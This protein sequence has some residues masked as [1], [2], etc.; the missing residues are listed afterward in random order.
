[1]KLYYWSKSRNTLHKLIQTNARKIVIKLILTYILPIF[2]FTL[3]VTEW[4]KTL[5]PNG[6]IGTFSKEKCCP[7]SWKYVQKIHWNI[8]LNQ[9]LMEFL[10]FSTF[11]IFWKSKT[12]LTSYELRVQI[13]ELRVQSHELQVQIDELQVQIHEL[14]VRVQELRVQID[15]LRVKIHELED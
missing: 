3:K 4:F 2:P 5:N 14:W 12:R 10:I 13:H 9:G 8:E 15:E 1:M 11:Y 7:N 6:N